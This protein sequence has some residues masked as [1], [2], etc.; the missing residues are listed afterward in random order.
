MLPKLRVLG[1]LRHVAV[2]P[3]P[4]MCFGPCGGVA[5][6]WLSVLEREPSACHRPP[7]SSSDVLEHHSKVGVGRGVWLRFDLDGL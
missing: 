2:H 4:S 5:D 1:E 7:V 6:L 3:H